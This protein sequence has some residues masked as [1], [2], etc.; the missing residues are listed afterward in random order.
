MKMRLIFILFVSFSLNGQ[1]TECPCCTENHAAF[2]FWLG[3]WE[4]VNLDGTKAGNNTIEKLE[5]GCVVKESWVGKD[6]KNTGTSLSFYNLKTKQW[7]Q[8]WVDNSGTHL[9][10][11]GNRQGNKMILSSDEFVHTD[12]NKYGNRITWTNNE[13]GTVRQ[14]WEVL[15]DKKVVS[16]AF[17]GLYKK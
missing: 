15:K 5:Q 8:L 7:E 13:D 11:T 14:R 12:G 9:K 16:V 1:T 10:L 17:D 2:D 6:G 3:N 4:V